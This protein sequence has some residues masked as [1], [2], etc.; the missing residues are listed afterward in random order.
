MHRKRAELFGITGE[1]LQIGNRMIQPAPY[2]TPDLHM[3][4][5]FLNG[6]MDR[7]FQIGI[8]F[9]RRKRF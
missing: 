5:F 9:F 3:R 8:V 6:C 4:S 2:A 7:K 1:Q